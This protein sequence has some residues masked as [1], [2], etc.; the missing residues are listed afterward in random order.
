MTKLLYVCL[1]FEIKIKLYH[2]KFKKGL[3]LV[4]YRIQDSDSDSD[5][6]GIFDSDSD[7]IS[8]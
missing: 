3:K 5:E 2:L 1:T 6:S 4:I 8:K 7:L